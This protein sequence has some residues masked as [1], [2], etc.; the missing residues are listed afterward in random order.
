MKTISLLLVISLSALLLGCEEQSSEQIVQK[1]ESINLQTTK[2]KVGKMTCQGCANGL[3]KKFSKVEGVQSVD[4]SYATSLAIVSFD[5][6]RVQTKS[7][8]DLIHISGY[9]TLWFE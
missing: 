6:S 5:P 8:S 1:K 9:E 3:I 2:I 4:V 7:F